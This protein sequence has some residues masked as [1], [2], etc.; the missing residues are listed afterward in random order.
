MDEDEVS[1]ARLSHLAHIES[2]DAGVNFETAYRLGRQKGYRLLAHT[3]NMIFIHE[4]FASIFPEAA[5][6][7]NYLSYFDRSWQRG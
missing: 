7:S 1:L 6:D 3:G 2:P 4:K 5:D